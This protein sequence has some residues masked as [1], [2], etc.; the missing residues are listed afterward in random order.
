MNMDVDLNTS[1]KSCGNHCLYVDTCY[2]GISPPNSGVH[3]LSCVYIGSI[4][5]DIHTVV[6]TD[7]EGTACLINLHKEENIK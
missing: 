5:T 4:V 7:S 3:G 2:I 1:I 6:V